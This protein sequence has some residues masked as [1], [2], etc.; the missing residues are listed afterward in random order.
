[1]MNF[2]AYREW[3]R[4]RKRFKNLKPKEIF[5]LDNYEFERLMAYSFS[6]HGYAYQVT[7]RIGGGIDIWVHKNNET[8]E[9]QVRRYP[10]GMVGDPEIREFFVDFH[11]SP[12]KHF[13][14]SSSEFTVS[15]R[16]WAKSKNM[17][18]LDGP[19]LSKLAEGD[20]APFG[21]SRRFSLIH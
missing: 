3:S 21:H 14:V 19:A 7:P 2:K 1:M 18:L 15:A 17:R 20:P 6:L 9:V 5:A 4:L 13:F 11:E 10:L 8:F 12:H 16:G